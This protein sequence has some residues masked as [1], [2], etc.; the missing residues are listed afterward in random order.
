MSRPRLPARAWL[1]NRLDLYLVVELG[2]PFLGGIA[3]VTFLFIMFQILRLADLFIT[4]HA[5]LN[6]LLKLA[7]IMVV[8]ALP[9]TIPMSFLM[10]MMMA[11]GRLSNDSEWIALKASGLSVPRLTA[12]FLAVALLTATTC[13]FLNLEWGPWAERSSLATVNKLSNTTAVS[14]IREGTFTTGFFGILIYAEHVNRRTGELDKVFIFDERESGHPMSVVAAKGQLL[15][16]RG[17]TDLEQAIVLRLFNGSIHNHDSTVPSYQKTDFNEY[18]L[19]LKV[20]EGKESYAVKQKF[21]SWGDLLEHRRETEPG[22]HYRREADAELWRRIAQ[23]LS[24]LIFVFLGIGLGTFQTRNIRAGA[25][26]VTIGVLLIYW[27]AQTFAMG[28]SITGKLPAALALQLPNLLLVA[29]S[30]PPYRKA[31]F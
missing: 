30:L 29:L 8:Q 16:V 7:G 3:M 21:L 9:G 15:P 26:L 10:A 4:H 17:E 18:K 19:Y 12:P 28:A 11:C 22:S 27:G 1:P 31:L 2:L 6:I 14:S 5:P 23:S 24:P 25:G 13:L 20:E